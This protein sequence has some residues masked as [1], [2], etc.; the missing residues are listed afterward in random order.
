MRH[1]ITFGQNRLDLDLPDDQTIPVQRQNAPPAVS[2][3]ASAV[4]DALEHPHGFPP[5]RQA[6]TPDDHVAIFVDE[7]L[8]H[9]P[10]LLVPLLEHLRS[11]GIAPSAITLLCSPPSTGQPWAELLPEEFQDVHIEIHDPSQRRKLSYLATTRQGR[12]IYLN[13]TAVDADQLILLT[14]RW[15]DP[16]LGIGGAEGSLFPT[17]SDDTTTNELAGRL[18][19][20]APGDDVWPVRQEAAEVAWLLGAPFL[21]Q[22]IPGDGDEVAQVVAGPVESSRAGQQALDARWRVEVD[23]PADM[24]VTAIGGDPVR[25][26]FSDLARAFLCASRVVRPG[27]SIVLLTDASPT[28]GA[29][30]DVLRRSEDPAPALK[31]LHQENPADLEAGFAW[32]SAA[33]RAKL[34]LL[35]RLAPDA[36]EE[37]F[38]TPLEHAVQVQRLL[39][40][41]GKCVVI[42]DAHR[43][44]A[45]LRESP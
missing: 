22:V 21:V 5:L 14:G 35:S 10:D 15:Y 36:V 28:L 42:P 7:R 37:M 31:F 24:V 44:L 30:A 25:H 20:E 19:Q 38:A 3:P 4:R 45:V 6:L 34:Y 32:A 8:P 1:P 18:S 43:T 13:R 11:A 2:D 12:R 26:T 40:G 9:L 23:V 41:A 33:Q 16:L 39:S 29:S 27:G 17:L